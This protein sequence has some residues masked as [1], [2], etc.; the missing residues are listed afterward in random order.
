MILSYLKSNKHYVFVVLYFFLSALLR[1]FDIIDITIP[2]L[3][4]LIFDINC[5][6]CGLTR[7]FIELLRFDFKAAWSY[8][9]MV[10]IIIPG[11]LYYMTK[12]Y[13]KFKNNKNDL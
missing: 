5:W 9:P 10:F 12:D 13:L 4:T 8:N 1:M 2:C 3:F 11:I 6:G 7:A